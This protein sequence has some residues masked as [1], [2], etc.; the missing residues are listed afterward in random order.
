MGTHALY[1]QVA[2]SDV[3]GLAAALA[4]KAASGHTHPLTPVVVP[5]AATITLDPTTLPN[6]SAAVNIT[7]TGNITGL[8]LSTTGAVDRQRVEVAVLASGATRAV[9]VV[10]AVGVTTGVGRGPYSPVS[11]QLWVGLFEYFSLASKWMLT[12][13]TVTSA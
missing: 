2:Q 4:A 5:F 10:S 11:G 13:A 9:T 3:A 1:G 12:A 7:A 6:P 8:D